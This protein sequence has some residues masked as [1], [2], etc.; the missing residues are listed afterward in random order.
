MQGGPSLN[1]DCGLFNS[2]FSNS[3]GVS[4]FTAKKNCD[5]VIASPL[6]LKAY[7]VVFV[8]LKYGKLRKFP[9]SSSDFYSTCLGKTSALPNPRKA[10]TEVSLSLISFA[11][12]G[13]VVN[14]KICAPPLLDL[15]KVRGS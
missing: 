10:L 13:V 2:N 11:S 9:V 14:K 3:S 12:T 8:E 5:S 1:S 7:L 15:H 4:L 6:K